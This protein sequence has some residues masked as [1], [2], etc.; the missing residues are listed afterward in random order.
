MTRDDDNRELLA[1]A[2]LA[3]VIIY[4]IVKLLCFMA[5]HC[6]RTLAVLIL[7]AVLAGGLVIIAPTHHHHQSHL[8]SGFCDARFCNPA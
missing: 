5:R 3:G 2:L 8:P 1:L 6:P 4:G 7:A